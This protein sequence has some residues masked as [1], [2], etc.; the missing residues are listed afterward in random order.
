MTATTAQ[1][2]GA[3]ADGVVACHECD[4]LHQLMPLAREQRA[5]CLRCGAVLY[6]NAREEIDDAL[7]WS[8]TAAMLFMIA[9]VFPF[10]GLKLQG[11]IEEN[12]VASGVIAMFRGG[13]PEIGVLVG[14][15]SIVFPALIITGMLWILVPLKLG[16]RP[17]AA[18][19]VF[20][21]IR[22]LSPW[23]LL[24]V[25]M[26]G[27]LI[28]FVKLGDI[29]TVLPGVSLFAFGGLMLAAA[30]AAGH[31]DASMLWQPAGPRLVLDA[32]RNTARE[33]DLESCHTCGLLV[34]LAGHHADK[35]RANEHQANEYPADVHR[36]QDDPGQDHHAKDNQAHSHHRACP[37]C[38]SALHGSRKRNSLTRTWALVI[39]AAV[40]CVPANVYPVM[41]VVQFGQGDPSTI[42][43]GVVQLVQQGMFG[44]AFIIF[45][46]SI[47]VP[48]LKL[49]LLVYLLLSVQ[50]RSAWSPRDRTR[51]YRI[52]EV[53]GA[54]SMV[55]I[56]LVAVLS[57]LV[58]LGT[59]ATIEAGIGASFFGGVV[60]ITMFAA[61]SFDPRLIWDH[62]VRDT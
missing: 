12:V 59:L 57:A 29:A 42:L 1:E 41:T 61:Q 24:G 31:F 45:F 18:T 52:T 6:R 20:R 5:H 37:R 50:R 14:L 22:A 2:M 23:T 19:Q 62:A 43:G 13:Q 55:D 4:A 56:F 54:W 10:L 35:F 51:L 8:I 53:V 16:F 47:V 33:F 40:L 9:N 25:F 28:A 3:H 46:A 21:V 44:L 49:V 60:V 30:A 15:T 11:R 48:A 26:L 36:G 38:G 39:A 27:V 34:K 7:A 17:P 32:Q 58:Q